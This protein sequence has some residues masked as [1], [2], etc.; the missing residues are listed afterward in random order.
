[1]QEGSDGI[2]CS[3]NNCPYI[4]VQF[5]CHRPALD[6]QKI[7]PHDGF[8]CMLYQQ[9][10]PLLRNMPSRHSMHR[11]EHT[12]HSIHVVL[13]QNRHTKQVGQRC[14]IGNVLLKHSIHG[15]CS[16]HHIRYNL[17]YGI[18]DPVIGTDS[19]QQIGLSQCLRMSRAL[20]QVCRFMQTTVQAA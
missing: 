2:P 9:T 8:H 1:M 16:V 18:G 3:L 11:F 5:D 13:D 19:L 10:S 7:L 20:L 15:G 14:A 17:T 4:G 12:V 6:R